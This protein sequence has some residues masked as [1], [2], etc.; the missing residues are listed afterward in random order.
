MVFTVTDCKLVWQIGMNILKSS[1]FLCVT[2]S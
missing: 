1:A 2:V